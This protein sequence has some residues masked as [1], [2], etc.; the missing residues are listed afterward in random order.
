MLAMRLNGQ[1]Y[2][3]IDRMTSKTVIG[4]ICREEETNMF[5]SGRITLRMLSSSCMKLFDMQDQDP[6]K[7]FLTLQIQRKKVLNGCL[8]SRTSSDPLKASLKRSISGLQKSSIRCLN[9]GFHCVR[10]CDGNCVDWVTALLG[11][12]SVEVLWINNAIYLHV[13]LLNL[14]YLEMPRSPFSGWLE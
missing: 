11:S 14:S 1:I 2:K 9:A 12:L 5:C 13:C 3:P 6:S 4:F 8:L 10:T 7:S